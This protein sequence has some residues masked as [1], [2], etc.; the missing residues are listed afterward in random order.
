MGLLID[1]G[2]GQPSMLDTS[3]RTLRGSRPHRIDQ[4]SGQPSMLDWLDRPVGRAELEA[5]LNSGVLVMEIL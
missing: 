4:G 1:Q 5:D 2:S 3:R